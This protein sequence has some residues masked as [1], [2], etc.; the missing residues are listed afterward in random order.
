MTPVKRGKGRVKSNFQNRT[1]ISKI[2]QHQFEI[3]S[4]TSLCCPK[5]QA[6]KFSK[7]FHEGFEKIDFFWGEGG[8]SKFQNRVWYRL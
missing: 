3:L 7:V 4:I 2:G 6:K 5:Y 8:G 1:T